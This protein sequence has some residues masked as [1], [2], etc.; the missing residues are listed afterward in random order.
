MLTQNRQ[1]E[2]HL[3]LQQFNSEQTREDDETPVSRE[4]PC[5]LP[6]N[7]ILAPSCVRWENFHPPLVSQSQRETIQIRAKK[8]KKTEYTYINSWRIKQIVIIQTNKNE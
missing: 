3:Q 4:F 5:T 6:V 8:K 7:K 2:I 1:R